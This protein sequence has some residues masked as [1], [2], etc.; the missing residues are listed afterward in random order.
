MFA[1]Y[2]RP[3]NDSAAIQARIRDSRC[4]PDEADE[5]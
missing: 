4:S 2:S 3:V 1:R 5:A